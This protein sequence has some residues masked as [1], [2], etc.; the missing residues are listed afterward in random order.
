M[1]QSRSLYVKNLNFKTSDASLGKHFSE[2]IKNGKVLSA[3][4]IHL[5]PTSGHLS[6]NCIQLHLLLF[7]HVQVKKHL[8]NGKNVSMGFGFLE[9]DCVET[10][11]T[12]CKALQVLFLAASAI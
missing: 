7:S 8:K 3:R 1:L 10:A 6:E 11:V 2:L 5:D 9:F 12:V 4:V